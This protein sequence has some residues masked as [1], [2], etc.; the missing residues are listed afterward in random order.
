MGKLAYNK[1][2]IYKLYFSFLAETREHIVLGFLLYRIV[3]K[4][5]IFFILKKNICSYI[6]WT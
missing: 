5:G 3:S 1:R 2:E 6:I 4:K